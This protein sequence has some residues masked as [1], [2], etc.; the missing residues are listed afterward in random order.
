MYSDMAGMNERS[1][2]Q[3]RVENEIFMHFSQDLR[4][5]RDPIL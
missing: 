1:I 4:G 2:S 5:I 3:P